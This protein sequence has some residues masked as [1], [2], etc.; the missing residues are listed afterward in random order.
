MCQGTVAV[1]LPDPLDVADDVKVLSPSSNRLGRLA[2]DF[3]CAVS[4]KTTVLVSTLKGAWP[5]RPRLADAV[6]VCASPAVRPKA[7][8]PSK[9]PLKS[10]LKA[11]SQKRSVGSTQRVQWSAPK[12]QLVQ[13]Y[14]ATTFD[15]TEPGPQDGG[16]TCDDCGEKLPMGLS[17]AVSKRPVVVRCIHCISCDSSK[18][19]ST[20]L[21]S[22]T[23]DSNWRLQLSDGDLVYVHRDGRRQSEAYSGCPGRVSAAV[24]TFQRRLEMDRWLMSPMG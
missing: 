7:Q 11:P 21:S 6:S 12:V 20:G 18:G 17:I 4:L 1:E 24:K 19:E 16:M 13:S 14:K 8:P 2:A 15:L 3:T 9:S 23:G 5:W 10:A 22:F